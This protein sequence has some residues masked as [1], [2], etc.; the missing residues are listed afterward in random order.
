MEKSNEDLQLKL[1]ELKK[2]EEEQVKKRQE[3]EAENEAMEKKMLAQEEVIEK[4]KIESRVNT[5]VD[6]CR[7]E[8]NE[9]T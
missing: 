9:S 8:G 5:E 2:T 7:R 1:S 4:L 6:K 3:T